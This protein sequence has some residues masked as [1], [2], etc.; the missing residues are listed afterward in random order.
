MRKLTNFKMK[1]NSMWLNSICSDCLEFWVPLKKSGYTR[2]QTGWRWEEAACSRW[3]MCWPVCHSPHCSLSSMI[4][5]PVSVADYFHILLPFL[6]WQ[7]S[8]SCIYRRGSLC[9]FLYLSLHHPLMPAASMFTFKLAIL[10]SPSGIFFLKLSLRFHKNPLHFCLPSVHK[11][12]SFTS[13]NNPKDPYYFLHFREELSPGEM[14]GCA[15]EHKWL[16]AEQSP[17]TKLDTFPVTLGCKVY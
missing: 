17:G 15:G 12:V 3:D 2:W 11:A 13:S 16:V 4:L 1:P 6:E 9:S 5:K 7:S 8:V 10:L 14:K